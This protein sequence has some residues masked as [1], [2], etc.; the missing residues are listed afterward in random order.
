VLDSV[1]LAAQ[2][3]ALSSERDAEVF[4]T[5]PH[6]VQRPQVGSDRCGRS[7]FRSSPIE[8]LVRDMHAARFHPPSAPVSHQMIGIHRL[9]RR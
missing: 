8:R 6:P 2:H 1:S 7:Y 5:V 4:P 9:G 3:D